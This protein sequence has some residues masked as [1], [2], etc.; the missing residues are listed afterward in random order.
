M[1]SITEDSA[2]VATEERPT[3][4]L[5][6]SARAL[7]ERIFEAGLGFMELLTVY[8][9]E[10]LGLYVTLAADG[11]ATPD[12]L[13]SRAGI[14]ERYARE[15]LEQQASAA[16]LEVD[17]PGKPA[18]ERRY[19]ISPGHATALADRNSPFYIAYLSRF[20]PGMGAQAP[21]VV[22][23]FRTGGGVPWSAFG[24][25]VIEAQGDYN[26]GWL[27]GAL[28]TQYLPAIPDVHA[29]LQ[30]NPPARVLDVACG[31]GWASIGIALSYPNVTVVGI[32]P[33]ESSI[34]LARKNAAE[35]GVGDRVRF[36]LKDARD[37]AA[38]SP[39]DLAI[40]V[41]SL[42]D[43]AQPVGVLAAIRRTLAPT[44]ALVVSDEKV[45]DAFTAPAE[46]AER[47]CYAS[48]VTVCLPMGMAE[49]PSAAIGTMIRPDTV[50]RLA[51]E[52][53]FSQV[54]ILDEVEHDAQRFYRL[55]P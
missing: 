21:A 51:S 28:G 49:Q 47:F 14:S 39:F 10:R 3:D 1:S 16:F 7:V 35:Y 45:G 2:A 46:F 19:S 52:A 32:D 17:D 26:R 41:E 53:G 5:A 29:R 34:A 33:D 23:A 38:D 18:G 12:E 44:G 30:G 48:S 54:R 31:A 6:E 15:W 24:P 36:E 22:E 4:G 43:M 40:L 50:R 27:L 11:P 20:V 37:V 42:H 9:G 8:V 25:D 13:A 55:D